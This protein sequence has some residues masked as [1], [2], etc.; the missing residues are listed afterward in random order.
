MRNDL[1]LSLRIQRGWTQEELSERSGISVRTIRNLECGRIHTPRRSSLDL[2]L[3]V[4]DPE[5]R[6]LARIGGTRDELGSDPAADLPPV[7]ENPTPGAAAGGSAPAGAPLG[8]AGRPERDPAPIK[9]PGLR[10][11]SVALTGSF[12]AWRGPQ[13]PRT[14]LIGRERELRRLT[15]AVGSAAVTVLTGPGGIGKTRLALEA[16]RRTAGA[17]P[18]GVAVA[19]L[20]RIAAAAAVNGGEGPTVL[21]AAQQ[22]VAEA[23]GAERQPRGGLATLLVLDTAEHLPQLTALLVEHLREAWP[24][25]RLIIT[26]RRRP[27]VPEALVLE[28]EPLSPEHS[29]QLICSRLASDS[30][31]SGMSDSPD[32]VTE[33]CKELD[34]VP[35]LIEFA[36]Y[37]LRNVPITALLSLEHVVE[38]LGF[39]DFS[40]LPHQRSLRDSLEWSW[41]PLTESQRRFLVRMAEHDRPVFSDAGDLAA[42]EPGVSHS[43]AVG[44]LA[45]LADASLLQ[46]SRGARYEYRMLRHVRAFVRHRSRVEPRTPAG[47]VP[48]CP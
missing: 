35:R 23:L 31:T 6:S 13:P 37:W 47:L 33:L 41:V 25:L 40:A 12:A 16:A 17:F 22:A 43:E 5:L 18:G 29:V 34:H 14:P 48:S 42:L 27:A 45:G 24:D 10:P 19:Q 46:V 44:L 9:G 21:S 11:T 4:L 3:S 2:L 30:V 7:A 36:A 1:L 39:P 38:L 32:L 28:I 26:T 8:R 15:E 20:G